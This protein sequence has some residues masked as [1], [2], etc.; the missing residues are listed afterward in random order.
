MH[1]N[2]NDQSLRSAITDA[3]IDIWRIDFFAM[4]AWCISCEDMHWEIINIYKYDELSTTF[5]KRK[6]WTSFP[7]TYERRK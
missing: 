2:R 5:Y 6:P 7:K 3:C 4:L 1:K